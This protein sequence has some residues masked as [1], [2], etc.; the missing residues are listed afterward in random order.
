M[1]KESNLFM[2]FIEFFK[3]RILKLWQSRIE[4]VKTIDFSV[5]LVSIYKFSVILKDKTKLLKIAILWCRKGYCFS[6]GT[7]SMLQND[8]API[9]K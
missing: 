2:I 8:D 4:F 5:K 7:P 1:C 3:F 9:I 6:G